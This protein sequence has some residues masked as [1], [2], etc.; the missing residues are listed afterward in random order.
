MKG[1]CPKGVLS[2]R[3]FVLGGFVLGGFVLEGFCPTP[4]TVF[5]VSYTL[6][7]FFWAAVTLHIKALSIYNESV[8]QKEQCTSGINKIL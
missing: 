3:G 4:G 1:F 2:H 7:L 6:H 5:I 8:H